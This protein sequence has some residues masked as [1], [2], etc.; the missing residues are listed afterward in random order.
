MSNIIELGDTVRDKISGFTGIVTAICDYL[1]ACH[2]VQ[3]QPDSLDENTGAPN[4]PAFFDAPQLDIVSK[5][6]HINTVN[7]DHDI[8]L[9]DRVIAKISKF[10]GIASSI[11]TFMDMVPR[12][13][14]QP[15]GIDEKTGTPQDPHEF[16][17]GSLDIIKKNVFEESFMGKTEDDKDEPKKS[18]GPDRGGFSLPSVIAR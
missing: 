13:G 1:H 7:I 12:I 8:E 5:G 3:I 15:E 11:T 6:T 18:G 14:V 2:R 17:A 9:G 10:E 4:K 16:S